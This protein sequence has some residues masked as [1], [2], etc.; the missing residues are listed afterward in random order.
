MS[1]LNP[2]EYKVTILETDFKV[3]LDQGCRTLLRA[4][5]QIV[6]K[7]QRYSFACPW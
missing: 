2:V 4:R 6:F 3:P 5:S 1:L 7:C